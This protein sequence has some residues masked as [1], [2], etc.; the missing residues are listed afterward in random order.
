MLEQRNKIA[1]ILLAAGTSSRFEG[2]H[3]LLQDVGGKPLLLHSLAP[4]LA[5][6][7][8]QIIA[9]TGYA[10]DQVAPLLEDHPVRIV[11]NENFRNGMGSSLAAAVKALDD[12]A[13]AALIFL[14][15]MPAIT[16]SL[17]KAIITAFHEDGSASIFAPTHQGRRGH[18]VLFARQHF[19]A[20]SRLNNDE[21]AKNIIRQ[22][23]AGLKL[24]PVAS[25]A[26]F[27][28]IDRLEDLAT[29]QN[30]VPD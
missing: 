12:E 22:N 2:R 9:V 27:R 8:H 23:K 11:H 26:I 24:I 21:G 20:L 28:D 15:D 30:L 5:S 3:K 4:I 6:P 19:P 29:S 25:D 18:P 14:A 17:I 10:A 13:E 1:A 7:F 16:P